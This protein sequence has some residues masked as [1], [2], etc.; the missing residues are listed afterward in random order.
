MKLL[1]SVLS[2]LNDKTLSVSILMDLSKAFD[3][4]DHNILLIK[5]QYYDIYGIPLCW[6]IATCPTGHSMLK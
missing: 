1:D 5:L 4:M 6:F 3:T 2:A